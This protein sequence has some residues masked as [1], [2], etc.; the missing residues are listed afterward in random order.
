MNNQGVVHVCQFV[1]WHDSCEKLLAVAGLVEAIGDYTTVLIKP[2]LVEALPPPITTPV[3]LVEAVVD[4]LQGRCPGLNLVIGEGSGAR[5]YETGRCFRELGYEEMAGRK[6]ITLLDLNTAPLR[7]RKL[8]QC[9]RWPEMYLPEI[10]YDA[11][12]LSIPV[13]KAH[14]LA[15]VTLTMKNMM[16]CA[17][18]AHYQKGGHWKKALFHDHIQEAVLD[19]N[20]YRTPDFTILDA[21]VGMQE[22]H[23]WGPTC[24]PPHRKLAA[25][26]DP[27]AIDVY[28]AGLLKRD[29]QRIDY[30]SGAHGELG[31]GTPLEIVEVL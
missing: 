29:W 12:L 26:T 8:D 22:A 25:S 6:S 17:P 23:L 11:F 24:E 28:G 2:N 14:S 13:L 20:R 1:N 10:V 5:E 15:N 30:L 18:P 21:T 27:V 7:Y 9:Q 19:L 4:F 31:R 16:G 3:G